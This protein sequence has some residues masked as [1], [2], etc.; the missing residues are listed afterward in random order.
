ALV[1][2]GRRSSGA[3]RL[4]LAVREITV[5]TLAFSSQQVGAGGG[6]TISVHVA[7]A[8]G[9]VSV[10]ID[11]FDP[12]QGWVFARLLHVAV[13]PGGAAIGWTPPVAGRWRARASFA[14]TAAASPSSSG[15]AYLGVG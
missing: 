11:R 7:T 13:G 6:V 3:Y 2:A 8:G 15:F 14:G 12:L 5:T 10:E 1:R 9:P 4:T